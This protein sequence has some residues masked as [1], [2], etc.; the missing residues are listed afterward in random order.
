MLLPSEDDDSLPHGFNS[1]V[2]IPPEDGR[3]TLRRLRTCPKP[4]AP[5]PDP[6]S[7][8]SNG[9]QAP[10]IPRADSIIGQ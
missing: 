9:R 5:E 10:M 2:S 8:R 4:F 1:G 3:R 7:G 6:K